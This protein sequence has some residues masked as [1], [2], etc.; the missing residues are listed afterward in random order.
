MLNPIRKSFTAA[1]L[2]TSF[3]V[4]FSLPVIADEG[5]YSCSTSEISKQS[6]AEK[7][8]SIK[9]VK[10]YLSLVKYQSQ[11]QKDAAVLKLSSKYHTNSKKLNAW[12]AHMEAAVSGSMGTGL[13]SSGSAVGVVSSSYSSSMASNTAL[14]T[15][16][17]LDR[18]N[19][20]AEAAEQV[21][22]AYESNTSDINNVFAIVAAEKKLHKAMQ[23]MDLD[24]WLAIIMD[25]FATSSKEQINWSLIVSELKEE[26][27]YTAMTDANKQIA[28]YHGKY[29]AEKKLDSA[30]KSKLSAIKNQTTTEIV[31]RSM[32]R[33]FASKTK[34]SALLKQLDLEVNELNKLSKLLSRF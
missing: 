7:V 20:I 11:K 8:S 26:I 13:I 27:L 10:A 21:A 15:Q 32:Q 31:N 2:A 22:S 25:K 4:T 18:M 5:A 9:D 28:N 24:T 14:T 12:A 6:S 29:S 17:L 19:T 33:V 23:G 3:T 1:I 30:R 16:E 34:D